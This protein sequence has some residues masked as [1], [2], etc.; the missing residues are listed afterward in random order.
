MNRIL[1]RSGNYPA[2]AAAA[3]L[4]S[5]PMGWV[6]EKSASRKIFKIIDE[7]AGFW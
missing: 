7:L 5:H 3:A 6:C 4:T 1:R 2:A